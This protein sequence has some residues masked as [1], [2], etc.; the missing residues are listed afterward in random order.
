MSDELHDDVGESLRSVMRDLG[1]AAP[2]E[3]PVEDVFGPFAYTKGVYEMRSKRWIWGAAAAAVLVLVVGVV[4]VLAADDDGSSTNV[5]A[6]P[7]AQSTAEPTQ[8]EPA[9]VGAEADAG[10]GLSESASV[11]ATV[12]P[13]G[14][15]VTFDVTSDPACAGVEVTVSATPATQGVPI[16]KIL[17]LDDTGAASVTDQLFGSRQAVQDW[18]VELVVV[19]TGGVAATASFAVGAFCDLEA[20]ADLQATY[21]PETHEVDIVFTVDPLCA[22]STFTFDPDN[23]FA[24]SPSGG[25]AVY[26]V[27]EDG[28]IEVTEQLVVSDQL[29]AVQAIQV[30]EERGIATGGVAQVTLDIGG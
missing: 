5:A 9:T 25:W 23:Y 4:A 8:S 22:G 2:P 7:T 14:E 18:I 26:T 6:D 16:E 13:S 1:D 21:L 17:T 11:T 28:R 24:S 30:A 12:D 19:D 10:C 3:P 15:S 20:T 29:I 27:D